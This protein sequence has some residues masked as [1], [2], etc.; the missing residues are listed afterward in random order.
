M[1]CKLL[2]EGTSHQLRNVRE[3]DA[4][5]RACGGK[6]RDSRGTNDSVDQS[7][8]MAGMPNSK[9]ASRRIIFPEC[10]LF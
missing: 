8:A 4:Q 7:S 2:S 5:R 3:L 1:M 10:R 6:R 9:G